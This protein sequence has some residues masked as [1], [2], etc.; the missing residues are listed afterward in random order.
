MTALAHETTVPAYP[1]GQPADGRARYGMTL[2]QA[3][4]YRWLVLN[5]P[6]NE[7]FLL[8]FHGACAEIGIH[9]N[10]M[11]QRVCA[12]VE[13]G[14]L[15]RVEGKARMT[16]DGPRKPLARYAFVHPVKLFKVPRG[17]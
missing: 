17:G 8:D 3:T 14:W 16:C 11:F 2:E 12:L 15:E 10:P 9:L 13:R 7:P 5:R 4:L 6:H 1:L